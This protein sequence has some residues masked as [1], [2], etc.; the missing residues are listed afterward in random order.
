MPAVDFDIDFDLGPLNA[1]IDRLRSR[2]P[3]RILELIAAELVTSIG[4]EAP[5]GLSG[6]LAS[7]WHAEER[8]DEEWTVRPGK[9]A[10]YAHM[11]AFGTTGHGPRDAPVMALPDGRFANYV[12]GRAADPFHERAQRDIE[13]RAEALVD[14]VLAE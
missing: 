4:R 14:Q 3:G 5:Q 7:D 10:F 1:E 9:D 13:G 12:A 8:S 2:I 6:D 11:V